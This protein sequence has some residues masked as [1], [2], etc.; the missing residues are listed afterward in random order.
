MGM[1]KLKNFGI[2]GPEDVAPSARSSWSR[3]CNINIDKT[4]RRVSVPGGF[5]G[6]EGKKYIAEGELFVPQQRHIDREFLNELSG[7]CL[8][9]KRFLFFLSKVYKNKH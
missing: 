5:F 9:E 6:G 8:R 7:F 4:V 2:H 3:N 1:H